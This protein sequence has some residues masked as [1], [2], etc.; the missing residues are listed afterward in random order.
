[1]RVGGGLM[2]GKLAQIWTNVDVSLNSTRN[3]ISR[4]NCHRLLS[5]TTTLPLHLSTPLPRF[6]RELEGVF[7]QL[8]APSL[9]SK[10]SQRGTGKYFQSYYYKNSYYWPIVL[11]C[12]LVHHPF[13]PPSLQMRVGGVVFSLLTTALSCDLC[14]GCWLVTAK[15]QHLVMEQSE[16]LLPIRLRW[17]NLLLEILKTFFRYYQF[18][19]LH[20]YLSIIWPKFSVLFQ[21]LRACCLLLTIRNNEV[22][23]LNSQVA[24]SG[25]I[26]N[27]YWFNLDPTRGVNNWIQETDETIQRCYLLPVCNH[28]VT[29]GGSCSN[30]VTQCKYLQIW[31]TGRCITSSLWFVWFI[32]TQ[33]IDMPVSGSSARKPQLLN[34]L[35]VKFHFL[36]DYICHIRLFGSTDSYSTQLVCGIYYELTWVPQANPVV[37]RACS[38]S[39][40]AALFSNKQEGC[41]K[42]NWPKS[43]EKGGTDKKWT[44]RSCRSCISTTE[45]CRPSFHIWE[46][47]PTTQLVRFCSAKQWWSSNQGGPSISMFL[48]S[49]EPK[50]NV[51]QEFMPK[52]KDHLLGW[53]LNRKFDGDD[54]DFYLSTWHC[55]NQIH[56]LWLATGLWHCE[57]TNTPI[58]HAPCTRRD[59]YQQPP[60]LVCSSPEDLSRLHSACWPKCWILLSKEDGVSFGAVAWPCTSALIWDKGGKTAPDWLCPRHWWLCLWLSG[61]IPDHSWLL[62]SSIICW[63]EDFEPSFHGWPITGLT[64]WWGGWLGCL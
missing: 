30:E 50:H 49:A 62:S 5:P 6:K 14:L 16:I 60:F 2:A 40:E 17:K 26:M 18:Q 4:L 64:K 12:G 51:M 29:S 45:L 46:L 19:V 55:Q 36:G 39:C 37:E 43:H 7:Q 21:H 9:A 32:L 52:L 1:M 8:F 63:W 54:H 28:W 24:C 56:N 34:I 15:C 58:C 42:A 23:I 25:E 44:T 22:A 31:R 13:P 59:S 53:L 61:S 10:V 3:G 35:T 48:N 38:L 11:G 27:A 33:L 47:K 57:P 20:N 41:H